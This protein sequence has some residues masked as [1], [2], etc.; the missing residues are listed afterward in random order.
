MAS[1]TWRA[2]PSSGNVI[3]ISVMTDG[4]LLG[5]GPANQLLTKPN[6]TTWLPVATNVP[7]RTVSV[8]QNGVLIGVGTNQLIYT[9]DTLYGQWKPFPHN[10][11]RFLDVI[12]LQ[13]QSFL[14][15]QTN[16]LLYS[17]A[18]PDSPWV[19]VANSAQLLSVAQASNGDLFGAGTD[20]QLWGCSD[21][22]EPWTR[23]KGTGPIISV[24]E[25]F[26]I[27]AGPMF[28]AV[29]TSNQLCQELGN[30][31]WVPVPYT[32]SMLAV[33]QMPDTSFVAIGT[34][35]QLYTCPALPSE[36]TTVPPTNGSFLCAAQ[37][38]DGGEEIF[39][40]VQTDNSLM[41]TY[42]L[43]A[44]WNAV[45]C[46][47]SLVS[48][49]QM[50]DG[51]L[52]GVGTDQQLWT[53]P[54]FGGTWT[55][56]PGSGSMLAV[57]QMTDGTLLGVGTD[58]QLATTTAIGV[59]WTSVT[60]SGPVTWVAQDLDGTLLG[61]QN[62]SISVGRY[63]HLL[64][65]IDH[66]VVFMLEN[67][68][69]DSLLGYL[70]SQDS[71]PVNIIPA[72]G[73]PFQGL[74]SFGSDLSPLANS[75]IINGQTVSVLPFTPVRATDSP[76]TDPYEEFEHVNMQ[77][78]GSE[79]SPATGTPATMNH[80]LADFAGHFPANPSPAQLAAMEQIMAIYTP[81]DVPVL[82][83]LAKSYAVSDEWFSSVPTQTN[84]N[85]AF[86]M[87]G[88]S[89][90][91]V[92]NGFHAPTKAAAKMALDFFRTETIF[93]VLQR[94]LFTNWGVFMQVPY[95]PFIQGDS[96][97]WNSFP[98]IEEYVP[99]AKSFFYDIKDFFTMA[100]IGTLPEFSFIEPYWGGQLW[101]YMIDGNDYHP[102]SDTYPGDLFLQQIFESLMQSPH[103]DTTLLV[104]TFDEHG[105]TYDHM[106]T[107]W[108]ATP[109]WGEGQAPFPLEQGFAFDR[110]GGRIP[111]LLISPRI[112]AETVF[113]STTSV[114]YDHTSV[115]ATVLDWQ[116]VD[117]R[118]WNLGGRTA[119]APTFDNVV[120]LT[121]PRTD[122]PFA[123]T[124]APPVQTPMNYGD[125]FYL[126]N[127]SSGQS[128]GNPYYT[129]A[130]PYYFPRLGTGP[131]VAHEFRLGYG[132]LLSGSQVQIFTTQFLPHNVHKEKGYVVMGGPSTA[133]GAWGN[134]HA[135]YYYP[136]EDY[137]NYQEQVWI[138]NKV[139]ANPGDPILYGDAV[140]FE[141]V[142][143]Q[144]GLVPSE[145]LLNT[146]LSTADGPGDVWVLTPAPG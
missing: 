95:P 145:Y 85:R 133:L 77:F 25:A 42:S 141:N 59:T 98:M 45:P 37:I 76:G 57:I 111:T 54:T 109:P 134:R 90:G 32:P 68:G 118:T 64:G 83:T 102:P 69:F 144:Q 48:I 39:V 91:E 104:I 125:R 120:T 100:K 63:S 26:N 94:S 65:A 114:P 4:T 110:F 10:S 92:N 127:Q 22:G 107:P 99:D 31:T 52:L 80:F 11:T 75:A 130:E 17:A 70:Y 81:V 84:A 103:W 128:V 5:I 49:T 143:Y 14:G 135:C 16:N 71:P 142:S 73:T 146:Y 113:R 88:T 101:K 66:I 7:M 139:G 12:Q 1:F 115:L 105:G 8:G 82:S 50:L 123:P 116:Q 132:P 124:P 36:W 97:T 112:E 108:G 3:S 33:A 38:N 121:T 35:N 62:Q 136:T 86:S 126:T 23:K 60:N 9:L 55:A 28:I 34:D 24:I 40:G 74:A 96:Y 30:W 58:L 41:S 78:F 122:N 67:R 93:N 21:A 140:T 19:P 72:S 51:T 2:V 44:P 53:C 106:P 138:I 6:V 61:V 137:K 18:K 87:T 129:K 15:I 46:N 43:S 89:L 27:T 13:D 20:N 56:H 79:T 117:K 29:N 131:A 47:A 119:A